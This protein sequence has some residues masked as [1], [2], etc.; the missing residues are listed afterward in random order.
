[1]R[2]KK[3]LVVISVLILMLVA[4]TI[5]LIQNNAP[6][7]NGYTATS[8]AMKYR[9][10]AG[11]GTVNAHFFFPFT[12]WTLTSRERNP[13]LVALTHIGLPGIPALIRL[14][15]KGPGTALQRIYW[16]FWEHIPVTFRKKLTTPPNIDPI[17]WKFDITELLCIVIICHRDEPNAQ[18]FTMPLFQEGL[19]TAK[20]NDFRNGI[21]FNLLAA[22]GIDDRA[23]EEYLLKQMTKRDVGFVFE[24][25]TAAASLRQPSP[26][27]YEL[28]ES[29]L[30]RSK[31]KNQR[32]I[33]FEA[34]GYL[35]R[36]NPAVREMLWKMFL[37][38]DPADQE[39]WRIGL[40]V[41]FYPKDLSDRMENTIHDW[42]NSTDRS[43]ES[44]RQQ[45]TA[46][47]K[48]RAANF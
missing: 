24:T 7:Y 14:R 18:Q 47:Y 17:Q 34:L 23:A 27:I 37:E 1:M 46:V 3:V 48:Y 45:W 36:T 4:V 42:L 20:S 10:R 41:G 2:R 44:L 8:W 19:A 5:N 31:P 26:Q 35:S 9:A 16:R 21:H 43:T 12:E 29:W 32:S 13:E 28:L 6:S 39:Y 25:G 15:D 11:S 40:G 30:Q 38:A 22:P 33:A